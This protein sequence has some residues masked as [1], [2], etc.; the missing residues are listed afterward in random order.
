MQISPPRARVIDITKEYAGRYIKILRP[1]DPDWDR[2]RKHVAWINATLCNTKYD[3]RGIMRFL[4][5]FKKWI[6]HHISRWFCSEGWL[7][8]IHTECPDI[9]PD[10]KPE[11][12]VPSHVFT[13]SK[14]KIIWEGYMPK[15]I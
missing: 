7:F 13:T 15:K 6:K 3:R 12:C 9:L 11:D 4:E 10:L 5:I 14:M 2:K 8:S 1:V